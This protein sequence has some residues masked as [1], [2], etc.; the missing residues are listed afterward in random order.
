MGDYLALNKLPTHDAG[1]DEDADGADAPNSDGSDGEADD[2]RAAAAVLPLSGFMLPFLRT[3]QSPAKKL[4]GIIKRLM[5]SLYSA[6][7]LRVGGVNSLARY[8]PAE[9]AVHATGHE[10]TNMSAMWNYLEANIALLMPSLCVLAGWPA[11]PHGQLGD[12]PVP[13]DLAAVH[14]NIPKSKAAFDNMLTVL[15]QLD[16]TSNPVH[17]PGGDL[18]PALEAA[19]ASMIMHYAP[20]G[21]ASS[22]GLVQDK[23]RAAWLVAFRSGDAAAGQ[24]HAH[25][26]LA[27]HSRT[28]KAKFDVDNLGVTTRKGDGEAGGPVFDRV[29]IALQ[30]LFKLLTALGTA[31]SQKKPHNPPRCFNTLFKSPPKHN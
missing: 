26:A 20:R 10:I 25:R 18:R 1:G 5:G 12:G 8:V 9:I 17:L 7:G 2:D 29:A 21:A 24:G 3:T 19:L 30:S 16:S 23:L 28:L 11:P 15:F 27:M 4:G 6:G 22:M 13:A 31:L 14:L